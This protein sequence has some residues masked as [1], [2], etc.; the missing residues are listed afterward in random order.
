MKMKKLLQV[1]ALLGMAMWASASRPVLAD[2][3][4]DSINETPCTTAN[5]H[6]TCTTSDG[7]PSSCTCRTNRWICFL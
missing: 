4:C 6:T 1:A 2:V 3:S 7:L 5:S